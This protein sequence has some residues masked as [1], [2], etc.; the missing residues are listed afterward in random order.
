MAAAIS[1]S[2]SLPSRHQFDGVAKAQVNDIAMRTDAD[3]AAE[4]PRKM[5]LAAAAHSRQRG[6][7]DRLIQVRHQIIPDLPEHGAAEHAIRRLGPCRMA[8]RKAAINR[9]AVSFQNSAPRG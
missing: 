8:G 9:L 7:I 2:G 3:L 1:A 6:D 5:E 4:Y